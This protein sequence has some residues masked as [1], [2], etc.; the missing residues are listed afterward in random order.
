MRVAIVSDC[1]FEA[2]RGHREDMRLEEPPKRLLVTF[3]PDRVRE[4]L[5]TY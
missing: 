1:R 5:V 3:S 2:N 4:G